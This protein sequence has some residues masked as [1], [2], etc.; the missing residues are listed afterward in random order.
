MLQK[1]QYVKLE[2][3]KIRFIDA[4]FQQEMT[5][6]QWIM[7]K[8]DFQNGNSVRQL[9]WFFGCLVEAHPS[10]RSVSV[11]QARKSQRLVC[12]EKKIMVRSLNQEWMIMARTIIN[13]LLGKITSNFI[14][15]FCC[16]FKISSSKSVEKWEMVISLKWHWQRRFWGLQVS[17][18]VTCATANRFG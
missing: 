18:T 9:N 6:S 12:F 15:V 2:G 5:I 16:K 17:Q 1:L 13:H 11:M 4:I 8:F 14:L 7:T 10:V 3:P